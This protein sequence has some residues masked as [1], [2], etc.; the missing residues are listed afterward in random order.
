[1][2]CYRPVTAWMPL[3]G[4]AI[5]FKEVKNAR[6]IKVNCNQC[7]GCRLRRQRDWA[8]RCYC[9]SRMHPIDQ[10]WFATLTYDDDN[11]PSDY[12]LNYR[13]IQLFHKRARKKLGSFRFFVC[14][15]YGETTLRPH[16]HALY[17]GLDLPDARK[18]NG[19]RSKHDIYSSEQLEQCW[20]KGNVALGRISWQSARYTAGYILKKDSRDERYERI[21]PVTGEICNVEREFGKM[22]LKPGIGATWF[23]KYYTDLNAGGIDGVVVNGTIHQTPKYFDAL[24]VGI[25]PE[26]AEGLIA[27]RVKEAVDNWENSTRE[28]LAVREKVAHA[29]EKFQ[30]ERKGYAL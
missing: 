7:I 26:M 10:C 27:D 23:E 20:G 28:R 29:R 5:S 24:L 12:S 17:F 22:S 9:E 4:G 1:M 8:V 2:P 14:G 3:D 13:D 15:E 16:Y 25:D 6:E 19:V 18:S 11:L 30:L 21:H